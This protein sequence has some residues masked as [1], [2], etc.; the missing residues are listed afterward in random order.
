[1]T[2]TKLFT[3]LALVAAIGFAAVPASAQQ[4]RGG[5]NG[6]GR[7][8]NGASRGAAVTRA[9][10]PSVYRGV[11]QPR[12][13]PVYRGGVRV[14]GPR[15]IYGSSA[16]F[17]RPYYAFRPHFNLGFG[18]WL[19]YPVSYPYYAYSYPYPY[20]YPYAYRYP[21]PYPPDPSV[22]GYRPPAYAYPAQPYPSAS[23]YS[24]SGGV[25]PNAGSA[26]Q[27]YPA[28]QSGSSIDVQSGQQP[29]PG[30]VSFEITPSAAAVFVDGT[31]VGTAAEFSPTS[32]P[33][34]LVSGRHRIEIRAEGYRTMTF[35][36]DITQ[37]QILPYQG[38]LQ[39]N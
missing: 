26:Q 15:V 33:L 39:P 21:Y 5:G 29:A 7:T 2:V 9:G 3:P 4:R 22:Y 8:Y 36:A 27:G 19:G 35:Q 1:M 24:A 25:D 14:V 23:G 16:H 30:G 17:Y 11:A 18:L 10:G 6:G 37:G 20:P 28:Q 32:Q 13:Y 12:G 34:G 38:T 31:Y